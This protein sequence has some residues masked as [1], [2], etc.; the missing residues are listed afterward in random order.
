MQATSR[1]VRRDAGDE[2]VACRKQVANGPAICDLSG[3]D[4]KRDAPGL[5]DWAGGSFFCDHSWPALS[6]NDVS[7]EAYRPIDPL[8]S[9]RYV[10]SVCRRVFQ[11]TTT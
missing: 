8:V 1:A 10:K 2:E 11:N 6:V 3:E 4:E 9:D 5:S 7:V